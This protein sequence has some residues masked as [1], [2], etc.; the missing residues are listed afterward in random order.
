MTTSA[1][2]A[3]LLLDIGMLTEIP[4]DVDDDPW[5]DEDLPTLLIDL[6]VAISVMGDDLENLE[7]GYDQLL[8][9]AAECAGGTMV[10]TDVRLASNDAELHFVRDG[11]PHSW[12]VEHP[13]GRHLDQLAVYEF[14]HLL[15]PADGRRFHALPRDYDTDSTYVLATDE[16]AKVLAD[17]LGL[18]FD[19]G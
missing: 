19:L 8:Q 9:D 6:G 17:R 1:E 13:T 2:L 18:G 5:D 10:I 4:D 16:Q 3:R 12:H 7:S 14:V 15:D 11:V